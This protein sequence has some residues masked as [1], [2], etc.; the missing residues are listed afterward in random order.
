MFASKASCITSKVALPLLVPSLRLFSVTAWLAGWCP[1][2]C[3]C[4]S[5]ARRE[6]HQSVYI[7][8]FLLGPHRA[9]TACR[10]TL[11]QCQFPAHT[12]GG[13]PSCFCA[14]RLLLVSASAKASC[15]S[16]SWLFTKSTQAHLGVVLC[17][18][19]IISLHLTCLPPGFPLLFSWWS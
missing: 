16:P 18:Y 10:A 14:V 2:G 8:S 1:A 9:W 19:I 5:S 17:T 11:A 13:V 12:S 3:G 6:S 4:F 15:F 7:Y